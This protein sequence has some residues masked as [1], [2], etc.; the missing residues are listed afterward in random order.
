MN[1][2]RKIFALINSAI[3][4]SSASHANT[5]LHAT[6]AFEKWETNTYLDYNYSAAEFPNTLYEF[7][8]LETTTIYYDESVPKQ[9]RI[10]NLNDFSLKLQGYMT[11]ISYNAKNKN[12]KFI[13]QIKGGDFLYYIGHDYAHNNFFE[14]GGLQLIKGNGI[15]KMADG[16]PADFIIEGK[17]QAING[18][19]QWASFHKNKYFDIEVEKKINCD[20]VQS[21][22]GCK[23]RVRLVRLQNIPVIIST[24]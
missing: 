19:E 18:N 17:I 14:T 4:C 15:I 12:T 23:Y 8:P 3:I 20:A 21:I 1:H 7:F 2:V 11:L 9:H 10:K 5:L 16:S 24:N 6:L 22:R 13:L